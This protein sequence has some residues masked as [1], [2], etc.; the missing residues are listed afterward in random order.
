MCFNPNQDHKPAWPARSP[1]PNQFTKEITKPL[2]TVSELKRDNHVN[3]PLL[4]VLSGISPTKVTVGWPKPRLITINT[5]GQV[6]P[7]GALEP[8][9]R[10]PKSHK[11]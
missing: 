9:V 4:W 7:V 2:K 5:G 3:S 8:V 1:S 10:R 11:S 6:E